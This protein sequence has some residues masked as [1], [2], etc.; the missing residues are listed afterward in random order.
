M[1][2]CIILYGE[3]DQN[4]VT[5]PPIRLA[6]H[7]RKEL[8]FLGPFGGLDR[9]DR[10]IQS[11]NFPWWNLVDACLEVAKALRTFSHRHGHTRDAEDIV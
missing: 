6:S 11:H 4:V 8:E 10:R 2:C 5:P 3:L 1:S 7:F 9:I